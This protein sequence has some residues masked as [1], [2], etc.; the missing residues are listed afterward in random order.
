MEFLNEC[1]LKEEEYAKVISQLFVT[2]LFT[3]D[4]KLT[5][6]DIGGLQF[7]YKEEP[8]WKESVTF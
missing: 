3:L 6:N 4:N 8:K 1:D 5:S 2:D 7:I